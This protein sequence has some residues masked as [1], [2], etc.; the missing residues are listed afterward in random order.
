VAATDAIWRRR[1]R[2]LADDIDHMGH[3]NNSVYLR[4]VQESI[5]ECWQTIAPPAD[6]T[7]YLWIA[8]RHSIEYRKP[9][10]LTDAVLADVF[11]VSVHGAQASYKTIIVVNDAIAA[12]IE[13]AWC[14]LDSSTRRPARINRQLRDILLNSNRNSRE[15]VPRPGMDAVFRC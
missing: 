6:F 12:V 8:L 1:I 10:L 14:C 5:V 3:V 2:I 7:R 9:V 11:A 4:W 13:S 15:S